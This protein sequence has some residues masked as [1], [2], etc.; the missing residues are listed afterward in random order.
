MPMLAL[1]AWQ[2]DY[3]PQF[4]NAFDTAAATGVDLTK[5]VW[6]QWVNKNGTGIE[7][8]P[9]Y[10]S[11]GTALPTNFPDPAFIPGGTVVNAAT[12]L[13]DAWKAWYSAITFTTAP[14]VPPFSVII[15]IVPS[16]VG[17]ATAYAALLSGL[18]AEMTLIPPD[19]L[20]AF[21]AKGI[22]Y[23]TLFYSACVTAGVQIDGIAIPGAP[24]PPLSLP[25]IPVI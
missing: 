16:Q 20:T 6:G 13:A 17:I 22:S 3:E 11:L 21:L 4:K 23:G 7:V 5:K 25:L 12:A 9:P 18:I 2:K 15:A 8:V 1:P 14:P 24:P 10:K 19:P